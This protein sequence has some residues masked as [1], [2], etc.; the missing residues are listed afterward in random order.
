[1]HCIVCYRDLANLEKTE[2]TKRES[3]KAPYVAWGQSAYPLCED[4]GLEH[5]VR[6][7][8]VTYEP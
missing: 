5:L 1:M 3:Q 2:D 8:R 6:E 4:Y 7:K